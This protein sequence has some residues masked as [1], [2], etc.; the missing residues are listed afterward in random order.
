M[1]KV[2]VI[3]ESQFLN[4]F[5]PVIQ[6]LNNIQSLLSQKFTARNLNISTKKLQDLRN[7]RKIGFI[8]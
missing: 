1:D 3:C 6:R 7:A 8:R 2:I 5:N 4:L